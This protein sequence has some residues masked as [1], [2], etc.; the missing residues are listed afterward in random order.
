MFLPL[1]TH[2]A[3]SYDFIQQHRFPMQKFRL[4][5]QVLQEQGIA[6]VSNTYR[7]GKAKRALLEATHCGEYLERFITNT[8][9]R[10]ELRRMGLPW[11]E[12]LVNRTL[13]SPSGT[14]LTCL[15]ALEHGIACHLAAGTHHAH[16]DFASGYCILN[17]LSL[18]HI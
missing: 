8:L 15:L 11:S 7:P 17:D 16:F 1:V 13:I 14:L 10:Q 2:P 5:H 3:Y 9:S 6:K 12:G 4:L 18:I